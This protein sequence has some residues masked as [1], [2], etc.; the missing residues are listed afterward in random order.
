VT[1]GE[2]AGGSPLRVWPDGRE[3]LT[4][5]DAWPPPSPP[6]PGGEPVATY[7]DRVIVGDPIVQALLSWGATIRGGL[8]PPS[9]GAVRPE[10]MTPRMVEKDMAIQ[11]VLFVLQ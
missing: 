3:S 6:A 8:K 5:P 4:L 2:R 1:G 11:G 7:R 10:G 9:L